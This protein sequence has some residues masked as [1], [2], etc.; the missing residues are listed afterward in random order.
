[1]YYLFFYNNTV[2]Q[3]KCPNNTVEY[4]PIIPLNSLYVPFIF[5]DNTV[6][7][8][9]CAKESKYTTCIA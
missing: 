1:M 5:C 8:F 2:K 7:K 9:K 6:K 4:V 3:S